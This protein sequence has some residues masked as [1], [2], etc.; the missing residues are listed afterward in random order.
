MY[1]KVQKLQSA[2]KAYKECMVTE[3]ESVCRGHKGA[4]GCAEIAWRGVESA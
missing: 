4:K 1:R 2:W 3:S